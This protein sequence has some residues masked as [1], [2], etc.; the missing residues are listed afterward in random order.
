MITRHSRAKARVFIPIVL[1]LAGFQPARGVVIGFEGTGVAPGGVISPVP[2]PYSE[3]GYVVRNALPAA[4]SGI[5]GMNF[6]GLPNSGSD[7]LGWAFN[8]A[9]L[10]EAEN[11]DPFT[12]NSFDAGHIGLPGG[13]PAVISLQVTGNLEAGGTVM[14]SVNF[15]NPWMTFVLPG[16]FTGLSSVVFL[17]PL[18]GGGGI[19]NIVINEGRSVPDTVDTLMVLSLSALALLCGQQVRRHVA[20]RKLDL[21]GVGAG[22]G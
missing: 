21:P 1:L 9:I 11:G 22:R 16:T 15:T 17:T 8:G 13:L 19:D 10:V 4:E 14:T 3:S 7:F 12:L 20:A 5:F 2:L 18:E 6:D